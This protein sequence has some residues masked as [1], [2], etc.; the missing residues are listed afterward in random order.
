MVFASPMNEL[1]PVQPLSCFTA[2]WQTARRRGDG[3]LTNSVT[4]SRVVAWDATGAGG[5]SDPPVQFGMVGYAD[6]LAGFVDA[7]GLDRPNVVGLSFGG[8]LALAFQDR[9]VAV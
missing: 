6:C 8:S 5:S 1:A 4:S 7:L 2:T 9:H 3:S